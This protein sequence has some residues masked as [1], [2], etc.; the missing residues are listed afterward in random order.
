MPEPAHV[1]LTLDRGLQI[2]RAFHAERA[3]LT[4]G[5][6]AHRTGMS[7]SAISRLTST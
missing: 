4:N 7:R 1:T 2:L 5:E 3:P 6:L